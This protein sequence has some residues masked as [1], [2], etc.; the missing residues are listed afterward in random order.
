M[1]EKCFAI[2]KKG[3]CSAL[4]VKAC[5]GYQQC[6][7]YKPIWMYQR[8]QDLIDVK[9][10]ALPQARQ[11]AIADKYHNGKTPWKGDHE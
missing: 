2:R 7:F 8:N 4:T 11:Q 3:A 1:N 6:P 9:L 10:C 5:I